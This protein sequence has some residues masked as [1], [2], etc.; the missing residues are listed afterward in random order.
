MNLNLDSELVFWMN[1][2][3]Y[4]RCTSAGCPV[5]KHIEMAK[6]NSSAVI[7][8][9][10]GRHDHDMP[11]PKKH[12]GPPSIAPASVNN[13]SQVTKSEPLQQDQVSAAAQWSAEKDGELTGKPL[14]AG[15]EKTMESA[16]T[17]LSIGFEI[18][19]C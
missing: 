17:L 10:K 6:D 9:Y 14:E 4:Y 18:K 5:R 15:G 12:H 8:T 13:T 3:N 16:R 11:V 2:R 19:P 1:L 7:I